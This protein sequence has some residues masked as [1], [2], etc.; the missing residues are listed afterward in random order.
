MAGS[1]V[2]VGVGIAG[3]FV[4]FVVMFFDQF[5]HTNFVVLVAFLVVH[6]SAEK[7]VRKGRRGR[8]GC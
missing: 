7:G 3:D 8:A 2:G 4:G 1:G 6:L 5:R